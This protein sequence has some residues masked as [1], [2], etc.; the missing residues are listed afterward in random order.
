MCTKPIVALHFHS[1]HTQSCPSSTRIISPSSSTL[2]R[3]THLTSPLFSLMFRNP[4]IIRSL[5]T[6]PRL[7]HFLSTHFLLA[8]FSPVCHSSTICLLSVTPSPIH[9][10]DLCLIFY[11]QLHP[12]AILSLD[13]HPHSTHLPTLIHACTQTTLSIHIAYST[14]IHRSIPTHTR[15]Q[16]IPLSTFT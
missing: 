7:Y 16:S 4:P 2:Q 1:F 9:S 13:T 5:L 3:P 6:L 11:L 15:P 12:Y 10:L 8:S 14:S